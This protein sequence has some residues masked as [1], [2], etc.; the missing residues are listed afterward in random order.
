MF[1]SAGCNI[2]TLYRKV[3][4]RRKL[5]EWVTAAQAERSA[6]HDLPSFLWFMLPAEMLTL[7][8]AGLTFLLRPSSLIVA[9]PFL[10]AWAVS[11]FVAYWVSQRTAPTHR[12]LAGDDLR[13]AR[14]VARRTWR[15]FET[16]VGAEDNWLPPDNF[17]ED[18]RPVIAHRTSPTNIGMLMLSTL[19]AHD[20]GY[21]STLDSSSDRT[22][23]AHLR[24]WES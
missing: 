10:V 17:Q 19:S 1:T 15:F 12:E 8:T 20:F 13:F 2:R 23:I 22:D 5:L 9:A 21:I 14:L 18:P 7:A 4:S 16:F 24:S 11:P 6:R 3:I